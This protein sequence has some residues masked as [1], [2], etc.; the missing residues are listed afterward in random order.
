MTFDLPERR[1][2]LSGVG[3]SAIGR[4]LAQSPLSLTLDA[5][6][7][8]VADAGL[9][10]DDIDGLATYPGMTLNFAPG[11]VGPDVYDVQDALGL[12]LGWHHGT[13]QGAAQIAPLVHAVMAVAAG[14][15]RHAVVFRTVTESSG[16]AAGPR[17][18]LG[19]KLNEVEGP[20]SMLLAVGAVSAANWA[21]FHAA[22]HMHEYGTTREQLGAIAITARM[23]AAS[24]PDA[25]FTKPLSM[26]DYLN[27]RLISRPLGLFDC[28][29]PI[30]ACTAVVVS[31]A[32]TTAD[33]RAPVRIE[34]MGTA[35]RHRPL[36]EQ[37]EDLTTMAAHDVA[38][39]MWGRTDLGPADV[40][41]AQ[42]YDGFTVFTLLW[43]EAMGFC[44]RGEAGA[45]IG[46][47][48]SLTVG[49]ALP[50]NTYGG[51]LSAGRLHG[52]GYVVEAVRQLRGEGLGVQVPDA[53]IA[54]VG[55]GGGTVAGCLL[56]TR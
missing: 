38:E 54:A 9:T 10:M 20:M 25:I 41:V 40:D 7:A 35:M 23:H 19:A 4:Q 33:L 34:A 28:D 42:L 47:G 56:L 48:S 32:D 37:W 6:Q 51:Q 8:A 30:D 17:S 39:Q 45:F 44:G 21:A 15:C 2:V 5:I 29:V 50:W 52:Y 22:R 24:N 13:P 55:I 49:G 46:D 27:A 1:A 11:F 26:E 31:A 14:L 18:G 12:Q 16:Q 43:L 3:Q 53:E 36:W